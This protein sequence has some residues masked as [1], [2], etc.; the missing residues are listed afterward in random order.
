MCHSA[1]CHISHLF[2]SGIVSIM[3]FQSAARQVVLRARGHIFK[4]R[5]NCEIL[6]NNLRF[7]IQLI[8]SFTCAASKAVHNDGCGPLPKMLEATAGEHPEFF[9]G[10]EG[11]GG[12]GADPEAMYNLF[13]FKNYLTEIM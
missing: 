12:R 1:L 3:R 2:D 9:L 4:L 8:A 5:I 7:A 10:G 13:D 11:G 6:K